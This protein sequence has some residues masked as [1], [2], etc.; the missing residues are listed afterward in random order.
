MKKNHRAKVRLLKKL[1][2]GPSK[3]EQEVVDR[4][5]CTPRLTIRAMLCKKKKKKK[6]VKNTMQLQESYVVS[7]HRKCL[8]RIPFITVQ[9]YATYFFIVCFFLS[10]YTFLFLLYACL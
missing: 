2:F 10:M 7:N 3:D 9:R 6:D 1:V 4:R 8:L 5:Q